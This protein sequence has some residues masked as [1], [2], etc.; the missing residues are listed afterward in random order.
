M[1]HKVTVAAFLAV[2]LM[3]AQVLLGAT[4]GGVKGRVLI[5]LQAIE[6]I[7]LTLVNVAT[8]QSYT[9]RTARDGSYS[10]SLPNGSYVV[11]N[12]SVRGLA[13]GKAPVLIQVSAG[14]F[15]SAN[16][17]MARALVQEGGTSIFHNPIGCVSTNQFP[18]FDSTFQP[19]GSVVSARLYFKSNLSDEWF[20][21]EFQTLTGDFPKYKWKM[22]PDPNNPD[23]TTEGDD[24]VRR[25]SDSGDPEPVSPGVPPTH[26]AFLPKIK[27]GSGITEVT[28]YIQ[29][30]LV[31]FTE[32]RTR[33]IPTRVLTGGEACKGGA[34]AA[35]AGAP[36]QGLAVLGSGGLAGAP[37]GFA[38]IGLNLIGPLASAGAG[39]LPII[40]TEIVDQGDNPGP[41]PT[42]TI[43][44]T[45]APPA[46][47]PTPTAAPTPIPTPSPAPAPPP[48]TPVPTPV[49][50]PAFCELIVSVN[51]PGG[52]YN[53][54]QA[55]VSGGSAAGVVTSSAAFTV[56]CTD[57][58]QISAILGPPASFTGNEVIAAWSGA[59]SGNAVGAPCVLTPRLPATSTV[60]LECGC[61]G[62]CG[63]TTPP[64]TPTPSPAPVRIR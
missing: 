45:P 4:Q 49:P 40:T 13:I 44:S 46:P 50:L 59:C 20:Y 2:G 52:V 7:P 19:A 55:S 53:P 28:Y 41:S 33:E 15:A 22:A 6:G 32:S 12:S 11:A 1:K 48:P 10:L 3:S 31:D 14:R 16:I 57:T 34:F 38:N 26:R 63:P 17:E 24:I 29:V 60:T 64:P 21:T 25:W 5:N 18:V 56:S 27:D 62:S 47:T 39:L 54:C 30:T 35:P 58:V 9:V 23:S 42:P 37:A 36:A 43:P 51:P 61:T 8:G